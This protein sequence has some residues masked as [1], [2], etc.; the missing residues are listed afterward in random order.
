MY[1]KNLMRASKHTPYLIFQKI[2]D[3]SLSS[4]FPAMQ[5]QLSTIF[6]TFFLV[7]AS[8]AL[9]GPWGLWVAAI[10][11]LAAL[12]FNR[13]E[14]MSYAAACA[15][16]L[17]FFG[18]I[19]KIHFTPA[20]AVAPEARRR[21]QCMNNLKQIGIALRNYHTENGH[22][23]AANMCNETGKPLFSWRVQ[24]LPMMRYGYL[25]S[26]LK[27]EEPWNSAQNIKLFNQVFIDAYK[28]PNDIRGT[29]DFTTN[30]VA[31]IGP[32]TA[33]RP[34]GPVKISDL[35]DGGAHT[36]MAVEVADSGVHWAEPR[37]LTVDEALERLK[38]GQG[39]RI[40]T[41]HP[42]IVNILFADGSVRYVRSKIP[43][44]LWRNILAGDVMDTNSSEDDAAESEPDMVDAST[45][46][47]SI[48]QPEKWAASLSGAVWFISVVLL[49]RRAIKSRRKP[50]MAELVE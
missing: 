45:P 36:V 8:L 49:F 4:L 22:F 15:L 43:I 20:I 24:I 50:V 46:R 27:K 7:A 14:N 10:V 3:L 35:P 6:L 47:P 11:L 9:C 25:Y 30:Y 2:P 12:C 39:L 17:I 5:Y 1:L 19:C 37:D 18:I 33:W 31:V 42:F 21:A 48:M 23:P 32:G 41:C 26:S 44:S 28:C 29:P 13:F 38:T 34:D 16:L 40:S